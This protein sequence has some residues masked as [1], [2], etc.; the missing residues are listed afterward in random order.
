MHQG[1]VHLPSIPFL[2]NGHTSYINQRGERMGKHVDYTVKH[3][4][5]VLLTY[6]R[7]LLSA[8]WRRVSYC[9]EAVMICCHVPLGEFVFKSEHHYDI[10]VKTKTITNYFYT[11]L[12]PP[13][14]S[15]TLLCIT[16]PCWAALLLPKSLS[17]CKQPGGVSNIR[18]RS[19]IRGTSA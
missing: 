10:D 7:L 8:D 5:A 13:H 3:N 6:S 14:I 4:E 1:L 18:N 12:Q 11:S 15:G 16:L 19:L 9:R 17:D 2:H